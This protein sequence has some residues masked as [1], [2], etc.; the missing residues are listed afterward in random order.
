MDQALGLSMNKPRKLFVLHITMFTYD[1]MFCCHL[2]LRIFMSVKVA[3]QYV[4]MFSTNKVGNMCTY[5][6]IQM[7]FSQIFFN[8]TTFKS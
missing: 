7:I 3:D 8:Q 1:Q 2:L 6:F 5:I 4:F